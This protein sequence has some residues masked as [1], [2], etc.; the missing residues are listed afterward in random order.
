MDTDLTC[1]P[2]RSVISLA[3]SSKIREALEEAVRLA[4]ERYAMSDLYEN[5]IP[6]DEIQREGP[7]AIDNRWE[8][9]RDAVAA[10]D[11]ANA[12][13]LRRTV[14]AGLE[15]FNRAESQPE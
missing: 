7:E 10:V 15:A 13:E 4:D 1:K 5:P 12:F 9:V 8:S 3:E 2:R 14:K 11:R 6:M